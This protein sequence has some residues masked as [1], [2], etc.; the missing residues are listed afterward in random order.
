MHPGNIFVDKNNVINNGYIVDCA[1]AG[2]LSN[3]ER[4]TLARMLQAIKRKYQNL[5]KL[6]INVVG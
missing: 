1:I 5:A 2:S 4:Y 3:E 6:F